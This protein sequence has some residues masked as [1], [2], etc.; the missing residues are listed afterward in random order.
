MTQA[1]DGMSTQSPN[2]ERN[3]PW[4]DDEPATPLISQRVMNGVSVVLVLALVLGS[5]S[6][7]VVLAE[8]SEDIGILVGLAVAITLLLAWFVLRSRASRR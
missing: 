7:V 5:A 3:D 8:Q 4:R 2:G 1:Q 6:A